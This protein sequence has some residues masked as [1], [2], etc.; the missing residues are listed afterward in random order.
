LTLWDVIH[1][2]DHPEI[3]TILVSLPKCLGLSLMLI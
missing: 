2:P 1:G 3:N